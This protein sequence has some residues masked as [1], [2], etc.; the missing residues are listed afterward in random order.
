MLALFRTFIRT[1]EAG[2]F[3]AVA[4]E[5]NSSQPTVSRQIALLED[6]LGCLLFQRTTRALTLTDDGRVFYD[7]AQRTVEAA[8]EAESAVGRRKGKPSGTLRL[9]CAGVFGR[10]HV[11]PRL[12]RF[13]ARYPDIEIALTMNDGFSDLVEEGIDLAIRVGET[14]DAS[15][16]SRRIATSRRVLVATPEYLAC[17][18]A[19]RHPADLA[20]HDC[21]VYDRLLT[22]ARW[23]FASSEGQISV[24]VAGPVHVNNTEAVRA[25]VLQ[26]LGI[27]YTPIWHFIDGEIENGRLV[28]LLRD[29]EPPPQP[30][31]A[32]YPSRRF[33]P[34]KVRAAIDYFAAE[35]DL[36]PRLGITAV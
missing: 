6:H 16:I 3:T 28:V 26:G 24:A 5:L 22:G 33:L 35:F 18:D 32:V 14:T 21:I 15:L 25:C 19:P 34:P 12:P 9:A 7:H 30:I 4:R 8:A 1:V 10:L 27:G 13:R 29:F 20:G 2:S 17:H 36:D 31:S 11:I 23:H